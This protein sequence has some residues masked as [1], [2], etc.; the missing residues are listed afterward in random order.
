MNTE[1]LRVLAIAAREGRIG[2]VIIDNRDLILWEGS[3]CFSKTPEKAALKLQAWI[4]EFEPDVVVSEQPHTAGKKGRK[5]VKTL[6]A[7]AKIAEERPIIGLQIER[8]RPFRNIFEEAKALAD[9]FPDLRGMVP[10]KPAI[11][12][13]SE[14]YSLVFF[15]AL[16]L[17]RDAGLLKRFDELPSDPQIGF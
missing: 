14:P 12:I 13:G 6:V 15:E 2:C 10:E 3:E 9:E 1:R 7:F 11:W 4:D 17:V 5:L 8:K 16:A